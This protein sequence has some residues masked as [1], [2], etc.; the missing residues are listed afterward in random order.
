MKSV[1][2]FYIITNSFILLTFNS[3]D[4]KLAVKFYIISTLGN[5]LK[6]KYI[7]YLACS[8]FTGY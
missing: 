5:I 6:H 1:L 3:I 2:S 4:S 8:L 7:N